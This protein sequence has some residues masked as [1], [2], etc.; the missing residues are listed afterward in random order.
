MGSTGIPVYN[1]S[2][3]CAAGGNA[4]NIGYT[5][6]ASGLHDMVLVVGGEKMPKGFIQT[7]GVE[8][9]TDPEYLRQ[10]CVGMPGPAFWAHA[11]PPPHGGL[12]HHRGAARED[13]GEGARRTR[14]HNPNARFRK[15]F[16]LEEVM[17]SRAGQLPAAPLRDLPGERRRRRGR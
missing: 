2:A 4:F 10:L 6:V 15:E 3:G 17:K 5:L 13:R 1:L 8:E 16:T 12:R 11:V 9:T 7:S 14:V